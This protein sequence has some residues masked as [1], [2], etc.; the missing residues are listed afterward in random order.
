[1]TSVGSRGGHPRAC[2]VES[3][4]RWASG[5]WPCSPPWARTLRAEI[6]VTSLTPEEASSLRVR[7]ALARCVSALRVSTTTPVLAGAQVSLARRRQTAEPLHARSPVS[8]RV[9]EPFVDVIIDFTWA[10]GR[11]VREP[12][13][14]CS[15][16]RPCAGGSP[17]TSATAPVGSPPGPAAC[18]SAHRSLLPR[19]RSP[20]CAPRA[21][22][23]VA[24]PRPAPPAAP[25]RCRGVGDEY[26]VRSAATR[27][28]ASRHATPRTGVSLDQMLV[29]LFRGN[30]QAFIDRQHEPAEGGSVVLNLPSADAATQGHAPT[31]RAR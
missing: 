18:A 7:V 30:P 26:R 22:K 21:A 5:V 23:P 31:R 14:C 10:S 8:G 13:P 16:R 20:G 12:T 2:G 27:C 24:P 25:A 11:L 15:T 9:S 28:R 6:D 17:A 29:S 19:P 4:G 1:M 3:A